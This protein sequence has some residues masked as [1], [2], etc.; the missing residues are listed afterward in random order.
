MPQFELN[1]R[2]I[3][4][5]NSNNYWLGVA[6]RTEDAASILLGLDM[7]SGFNFAYSYDI[8]TSGLNTV[9]NGSHE[10][11]LGYNFAVLK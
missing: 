6:Y 8:T 9:S 3:Y 2:G 11:T 10:I 7:G 5:L 1:A 4:K